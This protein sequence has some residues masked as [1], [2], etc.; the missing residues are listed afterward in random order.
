MLLCY[1]QVVSRDPK[2]SSKFHVEVVQGSK[3]TTMK[4]LLSHLTKKGEIVGLISVVSNVFCI[5]LFIPIWSCPFSCLF[6]S[7]SL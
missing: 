7:S 4:N 6:L 2:Y 1:D 5:G 3:G